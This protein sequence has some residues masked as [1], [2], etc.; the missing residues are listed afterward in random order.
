MW[1]TWAFI[2]RVNRYLLPSKIFSP[3]KLFYYTA[4]QFFFA[5]RTKKINEVDS[6]AFQEKEI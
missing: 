3:D 5:N 6:K 2:K 4:D 1:L